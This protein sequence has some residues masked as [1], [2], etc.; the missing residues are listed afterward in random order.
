[1]TLRKNVFTEFDVGNTSATS[2][3]STTATVSFS[4]AA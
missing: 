1:M 4:L 3:A 2:G